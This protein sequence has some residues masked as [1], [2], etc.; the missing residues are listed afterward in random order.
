MRPMT[1]RST[2][3]HGFQESIARRARE[4]WLQLGSPNGHDLAIWLMAERELLVFL[5]NSAPIID[6]AELQEMLDSYGQ[7]A[8]VRSPTSLNLT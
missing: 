5:Q 6:P 2:D 4:L 3:S 8:R 7:P 1:V